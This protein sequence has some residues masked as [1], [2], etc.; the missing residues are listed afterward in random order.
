MK[1]LVIQRKHMGD[2]LVSSTILHQLKK[3][4]PDSEIDFLVDNKH[5]QIL[6]GN[7][8][9]KNIILWN[10]ENIRKMILMTWKIR[11]NKYDIILDSSSKVNSGIITFFSN[12]KKR[13]G[14]FKKYTQ[15]FYNAPVKRKKETT[16]KNTTLSIEHRLQLLEPLDISFQE[17]F[18]KTYIL[19]EELS[20]AKHILSKNGLSTNDNL[21]MIS[22]FGSKEEKTYPIE[23]I[24]KILDYI[25]NFQKEAKLL[26]NYLP[27]QQALF[28][29][30]YDLVLPETRNAI[31]VD[32]D[33]RNLREFAAVTS[34]C[35]CLIGNEGGA[36]NLSKSLGIPTFS[37]FAPHVSISDWGWTSQPDRDMFLHLSDFVP[38]SSNYEDFKPEFLE[39]H[40]N[41]FLEKNICANNG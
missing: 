39:K 14:F 15:V 7:P 19:D 40:I 23:Y 6:F 22:T 30:V 13:I 28:S 17:V 29:R 24:A 37:I 26:C 3:K 11:R 2:V 33:T 31:V 12:A 32:F 38:N 34:L 10:E 1:I 5:Q 16:S 20:S 21:I 35:K 36:T 9:V 25:V 4:Y 18:P 27:H 41:T 8:L